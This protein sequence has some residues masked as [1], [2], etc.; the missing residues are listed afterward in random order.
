MAAHKSGFA[1]VA[2]SVIPTADEHGEIPSASWASYV[3]IHSHRA[4]RASQGPNSVLFGI[5]YRRDILEQEGLFD[6]TVRVSEDLEFNRRLREKGYHPL[7]DPK[8]VALHRYPTGLVG[9][10]FD[11]F[12]R[13]R[14]SAQ[15]ALSRSDVTLLRHFRATWR[16]SRQRVAAARLPR[17]DFDFGNPRAVMVMLH[18]LWWSHATGVLSAAI[19][20]K[21]GSPA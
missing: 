18:V 6:E 10:M 3:L 4:P 20:G 13:G 7:W 9:A 15:Y 19:G 16:R 1:L 5:S 14:R 21:R 8:V 11:Q 17:D 12:A 2:S